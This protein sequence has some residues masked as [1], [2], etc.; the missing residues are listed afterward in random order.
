MEGSPFSPSG[1]LLPPAATGGGAVLLA[2]V[3]WS[4]TT[5]SGMCGLWHLVKDVLGLAEM[6][7]EVKDGGTGRKEA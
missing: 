4:G 7:E 5:S 1:S 6:Q 3:P 2:E